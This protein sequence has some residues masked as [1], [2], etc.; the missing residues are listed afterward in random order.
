MVRSATGCLFLPSRSPLISPSSQ[1]FSLSPLPSW[2]LTPR[3]S[4][5]HN[6]SILP[7]SLSLSRRRRR[8]VSLISDPTKII[9]N[10]QQIKKTQLQVR[11]RKCTFARSGTMT[12]RKRNLREHQNTIDLYRF[13]FN[14][15]TIIVTPSLE[16]SCFI[17]RACLPFP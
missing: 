13:C 6:S 11:A 17:W 1:R 14:N 2:S 9:N 3:V 10:T 4:L 5:S 15:V 8:S 12:G 16:Y 7:L